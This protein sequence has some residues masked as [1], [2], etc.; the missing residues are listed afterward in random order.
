M[1]INRQKIK[2]RIADA[3]RNAFAERGTINVVLARGLS[4][5]VDAICDELEPTELEGFSVVVPEP[6][7]EKPKRH[8]FKKKEEYN[9]NRTA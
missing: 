7:V 6:E 2:D 8:Y 4:E 5:M 1:R 3:V 9:E